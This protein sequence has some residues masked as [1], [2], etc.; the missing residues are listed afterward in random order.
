MWF[1]CTAILQPGD[2]VI[3]T[4][5][6]FVSTIN[7]IIHAGGQPVLADIDPATLTI[8]ANE[9]TKKIT[10][11]TRAIVPVHFAG[12]ACNMDEIVDIADEHGLV[13]I[14]DCAHAI[15]TTYKGKHAGNFGLTGCFSFYATK[16]LTTAEGGMITTNDD[17]LA[18]QLKINALHGMSRDAW[19]RFSSSGY[20]HYDV[21]NAG[22]KYNMTDLQAALGIKQLE[23]IDRFWLRRQEIW[24]RYISEMSSLPLMLPPSKSTQNG[25]HAF[26]LFTIRVKDEETKITRDEICQELTKHKIGCG[27]HYQSVTEFD[28]FRKKFGW[29]NNIVPQAA[30]VGQTTFSLPLTPYLSDHQVSKIIRSMRSILS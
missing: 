27:V 23:K 20:K 19:K 3:T 28:Y 5:L 11:N 6:T 7:S 13:I 16:N 1:A 22:F 12:L 30:K 10:P 24:E 8:N 9:I 21:V 18:A 26:H 14:E 15:E 17:K 2:E 29:S 4:P 25:K